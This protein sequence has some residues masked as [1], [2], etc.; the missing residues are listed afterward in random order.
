[1]NTTVY[2]K[3]I[4]T[5]ETHGIRENQITFPYLTSFFQPFRLDPFLDGSYSR[6]INRG[7]PYLYPVQTFRIIRQIRINR[8][9]R[10]PTF[11]IHNIPQRFRKRMCKGRT[12]LL[13]KT[14]LRIRHACTPSKLRPSSL[15]NP[16]NFSSTA[17]SSF[18]MAASSLNVASKSIGASSSLVST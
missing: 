5:P 17:F 6:S 7:I 14:Q 11:N 16:A 15:K 13:F 4:R 9:R 1:M 2:L 10:P 12:I 3:K 18:S 8:P